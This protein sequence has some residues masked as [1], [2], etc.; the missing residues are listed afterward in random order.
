MT[1]LGQVASRAGCSLAT[2]S[3]VVNGTAPVSDEMVRKVRRAAAELGYRP[4]GSTAASK[5]RPVVGV[6]IPSITNPVF[7][8]SVSSI[9]IRMLVA[10][11]SNK[12]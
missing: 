4:A 2:A 8:A 11:Q 3:R 7:A 10:W 9:Q 5:R 6:L 12:I 1:T